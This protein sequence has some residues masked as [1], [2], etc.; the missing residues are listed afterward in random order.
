[1]KKT[2]L[3]RRGTA[4]LLALLLLLSLCPAALA[5]EKG[6]LSIGT[7]EELEDFAD[8]CASDTYSKDLTVVLTEDIDAAGT[9]IAIPIFCGTFDGQGHRIYNLELTRSASG[10]GFF[11]QIQKGAVVRNLSLVGETAP[12]GTQSQVGGVAGINY[13]RIENCRYTGAVIGEDTVGGIVGKNEEGGVVA[14]CTAA[15]VVRG[16][17]FTGGIAGQNAGTL[18]RCANTAAVNTTLDEADLSAADLENLE[19][20]VYSIVKKE[21]VTKG[22]V[23]ENAITSDTGGITGYSTGIV[24]SCTNSG[25]VGYPHVG[26]NVGGVAG[27]Q[28]GYMA[29]CINHGTVQGRKDVGGIVG[30]MAPDITLQTSGASLDTLKDDINSLQSLVDRMLDDA[31]ATSDTVSARMDRI[32][33]YADDALDSARSLTDRLGDFADDNLD[34]VNNIL[35]LAERYIAK[36]SP[37]TDGLAD[38]SDSLADTV[39]ALR[40]LLDDW[41]G[42]SGDG[43][44]LLAQLQNFCQET[45]KAC[46]DIESGAAALDRALALL[47][48]GPAGPDTAQLKADTAA[49]KQAVQTLENTISRALEELNVGGTVTEGTRKELRDN[50]TAILDCQKAIVRDLADV[51]TGTDFGALRD[52]NLETLRQIAKELHSAMDSFASAVGH[53]GKAMGYLGDALKTLR[54]LDIDTGKL[55]DALQSAGDAA[56]SLADALDKASKWA[57]DLSKED[58]GDFSQLGTGFDEDSDALNTSLSGMNQEL[59]AL[60]HEISGSTTTLLADVRA[61]N[62]KLMDVMNQFV[63]LLD[64]ALNTDASD[65]IED[66]SEESLQSAVRGKVLECE[67][68]GDVSADRNVGGVAGSMAIEYDL[69]PEDDLLPDGTSGVRLTYQTRAIL[70][71]CDNYGT[72]EARKSCAGGVAGRMD[73]GTI[74]GSGGWGTV[75]SGSGD[76][77]GGVCGLSVS[78]I[79]KSYAKCS[80]SGRKYVGGIVGSGN[81]VTDCI[82]MAEI[83]DYTQQGGAIAGEIT[84]EYSGN[85]FVSDDLAGVDRISFSGKADQVSYETLRERADLPD[86]FR[87]LT[88]SFQVDGRTLKKQLFNYGASFTEADYPTVPEQ[89]GSYVHW[90][91]TDLKNLRFDTV[92]SGEYKPYVTTLGSSQQRT[93]QRPVLLVQGKFREGDA[94]RVEDASD[95]VT[96]NVVECWNVQIP[97]DGQ[98]DHTVRWLIPEDGAKRLAVYVDTG[99]GAKKAE[100]EQNGSYLCFTMTGSGT[101]TVVSGDA[102]VRQLWIAAAVA[103][104]AVVVLLVLWRRRRRKKAAEPTARVRDTVKR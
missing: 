91:K 97:D 1:M 64:D 88:L 23:T 62:N 79:R 55:D 2:E 25:S 28:N 68:Y 26:Y 99:S 86:Q 17:E 33:A 40:D 12:E 11:G 46:E 58:P 10:Y 96:G 72:V 98:A 70:L 4:A 60:S 65:L 83:T 37:I 13:G 84:G 48:K 52:Q 74:Y 53:M 93:N 82:S 42:S 59:S 80:L 16:K 39:D 100:T 57:N 36:V 9:E 87:R 73:L 47:G 34:T 49:L 21:D 22:E 8:R 77:V 43:K 50:V 30:Q 75:S 95:Q 63:D 32:S 94:L 38:A 41:D 14:D 76:Y 20:T 61:V 6:T 15:G 7:L 67:N 66:V 69:D 3:R 18:L 71:S 44:T 81:R 56:E 51:I 24:Q 29:S 92:V 45:A 103:A 90:D 27:R 78:T 101:V 102:A 35:L 54:N 19:N 5:A 31:Q 104:L 85:L 89:E